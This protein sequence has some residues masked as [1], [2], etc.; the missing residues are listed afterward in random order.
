MATQLKKKEREGGLPSFFS[1]FFDFDKFFE[2]PFT[3]VPDGWTSQVPRANI[4]ERDQ[5]FDIEIAAPGMEKD[6]FEV[7]VENG[8]LSVR[9]EKEDTSEEEGERFTRKEYSYNSF[10]RSFPLPDSVKAEEV[11]ANYDN[12]VLT[13]KVPKKEEAQK[14]EKKQIEVK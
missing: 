11:D 5:E 2:S 14:K 1:D 9:A 13:I 3:P 12:G 10:S 7:K 4:K 8:V 6:D